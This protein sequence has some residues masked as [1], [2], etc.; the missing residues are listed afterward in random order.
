MKK[1]TKDQQPFQK[2]NQ[3]GE[4]DISNISKVNEKRGR[5]VDRKTINV[6]ISQKAF[7]RL[8][9]LSEEEQLSRQ[10]ILTRIIITQLQVYAKLRK[11]NSPT[12]RYNGDESLISPTNQEIR[13][14]GIEEERQVAYQITSRALKET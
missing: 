9:E 14:K 1:F 5:K 6:I 13:N 8:I 4:T 12:K 3:D 7:D 2:K 10:R 11:N